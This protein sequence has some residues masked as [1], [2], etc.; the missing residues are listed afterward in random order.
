MTRSALGFLSSFIQYYV[1]SAN[2]RKRSEECGEAE[3]IARA[4][5]D[6]FAGADLDSVTVLQLPLNDL[7]NY[8]YVS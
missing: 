4:V 5:R 7:Y 6:E 3:R 8:E 1:C 2:C